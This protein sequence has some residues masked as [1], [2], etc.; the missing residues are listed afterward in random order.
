MSNVNLNLSK[1]QLSRLRNGHSIQLRADQIGEGNNCVMLN[2][3]NFKKLSKAYRS[4]KGVRI[5]LD[6]DE[7]M[8]SGLMSKAKALG[9][10][11]L[12]NKQVRKLADKGLQKGLNYASDYAVSQGVDENAVN[13]IKKQAKKN[14]DKEVDNFVEG[15]DL[16]SEYENYKQGNGIFSKRNMRKGLKVGLKG[17]KQANKISHSLGYDSL[18]DMAIDGV[19]QNTVGKVDPT[20]LATQTI[21]NELKKQADKQIEKH[22]GGVRYASGFQKIGGSVPNHGNLIR[23]GNNG[24]FVSTRN[25][26]L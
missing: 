16:L 12:K 18:Q 11:A 10:T 1:S 14:I 20:G 4:G 26:F 7:I 6:N 25:D 22:G 17:L 23:N 9:K 21:S 15:G 8:G 19:L 2:P 13:F 24:R 3:L 5:Q